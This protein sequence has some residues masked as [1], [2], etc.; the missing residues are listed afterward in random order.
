M[1]T[2]HLTRLVAQH[3]VTVPR[4]GFD[5]ERGV[6]IMVSSTEAYE[7]QAGHLAY[8]ATKGAIVSMTLPMARDLAEYGVRVVSIAPGPFKTPMTG[9]LGI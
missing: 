5:G 2:F 3:L 4:E 6:I 7:G 1:G 9:M 8:A